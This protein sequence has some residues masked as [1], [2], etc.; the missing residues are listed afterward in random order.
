MTGTAACFMMLASVRHLA[1][2]AVAATLTG[3]LLDIYRPAMSAAVADLV[4]PHARPGA[5]ALIY[6]ALTS[7][8]RW[9][10][11]SAACWPTGR[12]GCC[13]PSTR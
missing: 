13:S 8:S 7:A 10:A 1:L 6:W 4:P 5:F 3:L 2:I 11:C 9:P 12:T